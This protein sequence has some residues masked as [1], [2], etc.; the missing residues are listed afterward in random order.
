MGIDRPSID[1]AC[2]L[3]DLERPWPRPQVLP[4]SLPTRAMRPQHRGLRARNMRT[5]VIG[6]EPQL[7]MLH[8]MAARV[9][10]REGD[11]APGEERRKDRGE[12]PITF[13]KLVR[14]TLLERDG[15]TAS[16]DAWHI[17]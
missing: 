15:G 5:G 13:G 7:L 14:G 17:A 11:R 8:D 1:D 2:I 16:G 3:V 10:E 12:K 9:G 6:G 4:F